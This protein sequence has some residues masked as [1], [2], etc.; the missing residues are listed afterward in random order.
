[1]RERCEREPELLRNGAGFV[2]YAL[3][4]A[5]VDRYFPVIDAL[6]VE[7]E[8][9][10]QQIFGQGGAARG[11]ELGGELCL[12]TVLDRARIAS[13]AQ[14]EERDEGHDSQNEDVFHAPHCAQHL[15]W[16]NQPRL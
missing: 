7:L 6:E 14:R 15:L 3:M 11:V 10:E 4:D 8:A 9:I 2:L 12:L 13:E 16:P 1:M 5:V